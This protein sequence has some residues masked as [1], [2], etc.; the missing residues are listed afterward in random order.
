VSEPPQPGY[1]STPFADSAL[2]GVQAFRHSGIQNEG[3]GFAVQGPGEGAQAF[4]HS[5]IQE[6]QPVRRSS[7]IPHPSSFPTPNTQHPTPNTQPAIPQLT[8]L[9]QTQE[10]FLIAEGGGRLWIIDQ[11]VA[12]E[13]VLFDRLTASSDPEASEALLIPVTVEL[14]RSRSLALDEN[15]EA[16][17]ELGFVIE[18]FGAGRYLLRSVPR[19]LLGRNY[20]VAFRDMADE[21]SEL[22]RGGQVRLRR[23]EVAMAAAGRSCKSA[24]KAGQKLSTGE[25]EQLLADLRHARNPHTCPHGRPVFLT[26]EPADLDRLF[27]PRPCRVS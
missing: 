5:G 25:I 3:S 2:G 16:L 24:V 11:H 19:S 21:L 20:E 4:R 6:G 17:A 18:P 9:G 8:Y 1:A 15:R 10:L 13:R 26:Y 23:E 7:L 27:G 14:D 22:S 12:H